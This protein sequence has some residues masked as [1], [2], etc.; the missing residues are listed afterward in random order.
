MR[1]KTQM[2]YVLSVFSGERGIPPCGLADERS[3]AESGGEG[4]GSTTRPSGTLLSTKR[5]ERERTGVD[6]RTRI[7]PLVKDAGMA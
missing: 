1:S 4:K 6:V 3:L 5:R 2:G 7:A